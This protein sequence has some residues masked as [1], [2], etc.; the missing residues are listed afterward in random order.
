MSSAYTLSAVVATGDAFNRQRSSQPA[1]IF[2]L[3]FQYDTQPL[4]MQY[5]N[6]GTGSTVKTA[7]E[8]SLTLSTGGTASGAQAVAQTKEYFAYEP[9]KSQLALMSGVLGVQTANVT[10]RIG[11]F[12][13]NNGVFF[14]MSGAT[15]PACVLRTN[16]SGSV[17]ET[18]ILLAN[19]SQ[20]S[21]ESGIPL[22]N[23]FVDFSKAQIFVIDFQWLGCGRIRFG[24]FINGVIEYLNIINMG[25]VISGPYMNT[26]CLPCRYEITNNAVAAAATTMKLICLS[27]VSEAGQEKPVLLNFSANTKTT[28]DSVTTRRPILSIQPKLLFGGLAN[29]GRVY[30]LLAELVVN[31]AATLYEIVYDGVLTGATFNSVDPNSLCNFDT[32]ATAISGGTVYK[33][34]FGIANFQNVIDILCRYPVTLNFA[35]TVPDTISIVA[36]S[37]SGTATVGASITWEELR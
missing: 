35:G 10:S 23:V 7:N 28:L 18:R 4:F 2:Q 9:G 36:T 34:G 21:L 12:D 5:A 25:G 6:T 24:V 8:S 32:A 16:A 29:R 33:T 20:T 30:P 26:G 3:L 11:Y 27:V 1:T 17:V 37:L 15:G 13:A 19:W 14:E 22:A 31:T